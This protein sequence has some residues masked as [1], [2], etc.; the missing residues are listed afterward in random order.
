MEETE[1]GSHLDEPREGSEIDAQVP[2]T[3]SG[4]RKR[5]MQGCGE[6]AELCLGRYNWKTPRRGRPASI[7]AA[8][9]GP[10]GTCV[11]WP[12]KLSLSLPSV[13]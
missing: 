2:F 5:K 6:R 3:V 13:G 10:E 7:S 8:P 12:L 9:T 1:P 11:P 4:N